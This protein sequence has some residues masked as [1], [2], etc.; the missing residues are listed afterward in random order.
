M[1]DYATTNTT[2][3]APTDPSVVERAW[4]LRPALDF[5]PLMSQTF[6]PRT[7]VPE[8]SAPRSN[9]GVVFPR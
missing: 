3:G 9:V 5:S 8:G 2:P 1:S 6:Y 7:P 4:F